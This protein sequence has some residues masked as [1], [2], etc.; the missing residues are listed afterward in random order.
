MPALVDWPRLSLACYN[1]SVVV[2]RALC[3]V[4]FCV[5]SQAGPKEA[6]VAQQP[7]AD[8]TSALVC[9]QNALGGTAAFA[10]V[11]SLYIKGETKPSRD[12]GL[13][14]NPGTREISVVFPDRYLRSEF[15]Q[16]LRPG[17]GGLN[18]SVGF[19]KSIIL[20]SPRHPDAK[21]S[22]I[23]AHQ[24]FAR[25]M[26]MRLPGRSAGVRLLQ[27]V[28]SDLGLDRLAIEASGADGFRATLLVDRGSC[29]PIALQFTT[30]GAAVSGIRRVDLTEYRAFG[31]VR[32]PTVLKTSI[33]G[34]H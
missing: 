22:D 10:A 14:P 13:R 21:V 7:A 29:V 27:R 18:S 16:P 28:T 1:E 31:G 17:E 6:M 12:S 26:L 32:F 8:A 11:S 23:S 25:Q 3:L 15:A 20:S 9:I 5:V 24:D 19:D 30:I 33:A 2:M 4:V 34:W